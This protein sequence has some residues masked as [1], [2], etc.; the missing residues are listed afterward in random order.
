[1]QRAIDYLLLSVLSYCNFTEKDYGSTLEKVYTT[2]E[3][4]KIENNGFYFCT[5]ET[6]YLFHD[7]FKEILGNWEIF[8][9]E[10]KR[11]GVIPNASGF[12]SVVFKNRLTN[13]YVIAFRGSEKYPLED[14]YKDFIET[15]LKIGMG[16]KPR[17]FYDGLEVLYKLIDKFK[18]PENKIFITGHSLGGG[19]S[20]FVSMMCDKERGFI[21]YTCTWNAVGINR[22]GIVNILDFLDYNKIIDKLNLEDNEKKY[23][24][25]FKEEYLDFFLKELKKGKVVK[26]NNMLLI[27]KE[28][29][30]N[31]NVDENFKKNFLKSTKFE[32]VL[33]KLSGKTKIKLLDN[34]RVFDALFKVDNLVDELFQADYFI[35]RVKD[36]TVYQDRII[37]FCHS[38]DMTVSFFRHIGSVYQVDQ[39]F[40]RKDMKKR[41]IFSSFNFLTK[42]VQDYHYQ[43]VFLP[44]I[45]V[46]GEKKGMFSKKIAIGYLGSVLRKV[47]NLGYCME[48]EVLAEYFSLV[49]INHENYKKIK[50]M[51]I[52]GI[53]KAGVTILYKDQVY[54]QIKN[55]DMEEFS[56]VWEDA[57]KKLPSPYRIQDIYDLILFHKE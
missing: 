22:D 8:Y 1:M 26:N 43:D 11:A 35:R 31:P 10:D 38:E 16:V 49:E 25:E 7:F 50:D 3:Y 29:Q 54:E 57:K 9:V 53:K 20:Q 17:Q 56:K 33:R 37:N 2:V 45:Q 23:F 24:L 51:V 13:N 30:F 12:Y 32:E 14:A 5:E 6:R 18:I 46:S 36:N 52:Q 41:T 44:F 39:N 34:G 40:L 4:E 55:M 27:K 42:S 48:K 19:I 47:I 28:S 15:D 21:P